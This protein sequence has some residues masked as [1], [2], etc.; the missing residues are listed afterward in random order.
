MPGDFEIV[1]DL[2]ASGRYMAGLKDKVDKRM[3]KMALDTAAGATHNTVRVITGN[4]KNSW[5]VR[6]MGFLD[7]IV[8]SFGAD[9]A[10]YHELGT[11]FMS[12]TPMLMPSFA[13]EWATFKAALT[14]EGIL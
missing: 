4:M 3:H 2:S 9:Y 11:R 14:V 10:I 7:Y 12:A 5:G 6:R 8:G 1:I 13:L